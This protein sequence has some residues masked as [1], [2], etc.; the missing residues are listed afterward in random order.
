MTDLNSGKPWSQM[1]LNDLR[2]YAKGG[3]DWLATYLMRDRE[4]VREKLEGLKRGG[5]W[6]GGTAR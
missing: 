3:P 6:P 1:D 4:E 5:P 2:D